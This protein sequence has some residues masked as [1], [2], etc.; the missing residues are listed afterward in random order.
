[1]KNKESKTESIL[2]IIVAIIESIVAIYAIMSGITII[3]IFGIIAL[4]MAALNVLIRSV[5][6][7]NIKI[8][9]TQNT[10]GDD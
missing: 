1:M 3:T 2:H 8:E 6:I 4:V 10:S 9:S 5:Y 7:V